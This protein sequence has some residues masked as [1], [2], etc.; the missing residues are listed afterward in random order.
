[1]EVPEIAAAAL[2]R[3][4]KILVAQ[5]SKPMPT[6]LLGFA[7]NVR[8]FVGQMFAQQLRTLRAF[9][10]GKKELSRSN[11]RIRIQPHYS[12]RQAYLGHEQVGLLVEFLP[13]AD[14]HLLPVHPG[15]ARELPLPSRS[16]RTPLSYIAENVVP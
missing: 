13:Q 3:E 12:I 9:T 8:C 4:V 2:N 10:V 6:N 7:Q 15:Y 1:M 16:H 5:Q 14:P 11:R